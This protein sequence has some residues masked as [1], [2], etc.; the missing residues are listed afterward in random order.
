MRMGRGQASAREQGA[1][2][3]DAGGA[4]NLFHGRVNSSG[5][6]VSDDVHT[7]GRLRFPGRSRVS[8][9]PRPTDAVGLGGL[10]TS[11]RIAEIFITISSNL[12][13][14]NKTQVRMEG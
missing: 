10:S 6:C 12:F 4:A 11:F 2:N 5:P 1:Q 8:N 14:R 13:R 7:P 9:H 3:L